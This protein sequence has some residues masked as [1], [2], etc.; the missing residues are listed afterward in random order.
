MNCSVVACDGLRKKS[1]Q[2]VPADREELVSKKSGEKR[3]FA[4]AD[5]NQIEHKA[6][7]EAREKRGE[8][9]LSTRK[10]RIPQK[11]I[12]LGKERRDKKKVRKHRPSYRRVG[13]RAWNKTCRRVKRRF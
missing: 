12:I 6:H 4:I 13:A 7:K 2:R 8:L 1:T 9:T 5:D 10:R 11:E 3:F